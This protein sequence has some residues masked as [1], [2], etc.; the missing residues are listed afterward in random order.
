MASLAWVSVLFVVMVVAQ[1]F[2]GV[3]VKGQQNVFAFRK[4]MLE[5]YVFYNRSCLQL[6]SCC[7]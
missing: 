1:L 3:D 2:A 6:Q 5:E 4:V 7:P